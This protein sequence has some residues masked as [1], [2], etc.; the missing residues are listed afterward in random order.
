[1]MKKRAKEKFQL[2]PMTSSIA[3][4]SVV[5]Y[6]FGAISFLVGAFFL[7]SVF[8]PSGVFMAFGGTTMGRATAVFVLT[9]VGGSSLWAAHELRRMEKAAAVLALSLCLA[10]ISLSVFIHAF[11]PGYLLQPL[12]LNIIWWWPLPIAVAIIIWRNWGKMQ[13]RSEFRMY[14]GKTAKREKKENQ[15]S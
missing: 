6:V 7:V 9:F 3:H 12:Y 2:A 11:P 10:I 4:A 15:R 14:F 8:V 5:I 1:M 13:W